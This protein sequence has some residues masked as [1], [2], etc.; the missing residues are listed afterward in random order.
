MEAALIAATFG[1]AAI[2]I[3]GLVYAGTARAARSGIN[4]GVVAAGAA[5]VLAWAGIDIALAVRGSFASV[6]AS[7][8]PGIVAGIAVPIVAGNVAM[9][10]LPSVRRLIRAIPTPWLIGV[11][12]YRVLGALFLIDYARHH[13][14]GPFALPAGIGDIAVGL[15]AP[16]AAY[17]LVKAP[18]L[19]TR[20]AVAW[21]VLGIADLVAA[22]AMGFLT[23]PSPLQALAL[24]HPNYAISRYPFVLIPVFLVPASI[25]LHVATLRRLRE[26]AHPATATAKARPGTTTWRPA[27]PQSRVSSAG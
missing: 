15:L 6:H 1:L 27:Q 18:R 13:M 23:S 19:G 12:L 2:L 9:V 5:L 24:T 16:A 10:A 25:L 8:V 20:I 11:Q 21:N 26:A 22:V 4:R 14:P 3:A 17:A 7:Y